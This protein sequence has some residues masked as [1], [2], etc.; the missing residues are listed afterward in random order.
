MYEVDRVP[1]TGQNAR[2]SR[3]VPFV[4]VDA[5]QAAAGKRLIQPCERAAEAASGIQN[6]LTVGHTS[7]VQQAAAEALGAPA[8]SAMLPS[9]CFGSPQ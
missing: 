3:N 5:V 8:K 4:D 6:V 7:R 1:G 2:G 9:A